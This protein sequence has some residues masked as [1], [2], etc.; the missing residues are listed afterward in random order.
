MHCLQ[1]IISHTHNICHIVFQVQYTKYGTFFWHFINLLEIVEAMSCAAYLLSISGLKKELWYYVTEVSM[2]Q[3]ECVFCCRWR[4]FKKNNKKPWLRLAEFWRILIKPGEY[5]MNENGNT[6]AAVGRKTRVL[7]SATG[8]IKAERH[9]CFSTLKEWPC[10]P[11]GSKHERHV[12]KRFLSQKTHSH[13]VS[14][15]AAVYISLCHE[16]PSKT[17]S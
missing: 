1:F 10:R 11:E 4:I 15:F 2:S 3:R 6:S 8:D 9:E 7:Q 16:L 17:C 12:E 13:T 14:P 5:I